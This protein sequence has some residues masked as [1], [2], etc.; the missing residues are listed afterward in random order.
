[1]G[2]HSGELAARRAERA[3]RDTP[4]VDIYLTVAGL[5]ARGSRLLPGLPAASGSDT[6]DRSSPPTVAGAAPALNRIPS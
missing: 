6:F 5:L 1:M 4:P 3:R 2:T